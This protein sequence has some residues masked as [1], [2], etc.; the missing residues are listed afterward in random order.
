MEQ[1]TDALYTT[2]MSRLTAVA[3]NS[4]GELQLAEQSFRVAQEAMQELKAFIKQ[5]HRFTSV[6]VEI[7]FFKEIKPRFHREVIYYAEL[8]HILIN[9]PSGPKKSIIKYYEQHMAQIQA[10]F[11][12]HRLLKTYCEMKHT[13]HDELLFVRE[14]DCVPLTPDDTSEIDTSFC[15]VNGSIIAKLSAFERVMEYLA[16]KVSHLKYGNREHNSTP[17]DRQL[18]T[19]SKAALIELAYA[20]HARGAVNNGQGDVKSLISSL[21]QLF[22][23]EVGNFYRT[24]QGMRIRKKNRTSFL[25]NLKNSLEQRMDEGWE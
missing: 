15:T 14:S 7:R 22:R 21:E 5:E 6:A 19:D 16:H 11:S 9:K 20:L 23:V 10:F 8:I 1:Y 25:D 2:M 3:R 13:E 24:Y 4:E 18:W 17:A 12:R